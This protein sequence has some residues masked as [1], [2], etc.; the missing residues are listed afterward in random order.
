MQFNGWIF[1]I[2]GNIYFIEYDTKFD[3]CIKIVKNM[4]IQR[5]DF[6]NMK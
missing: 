5:L 6:Q 3:M 4:Q 1:K 2:C